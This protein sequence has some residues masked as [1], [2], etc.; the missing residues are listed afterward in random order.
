MYCE[1][2]DDLCFLVYGDQPIVRWLE[3]FTVA[4]VAEDLEVHFSL[5]QLQC[6][7]FNIPSSDVKLRDRQGS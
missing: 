2:P 4:I 7:N 1:L 6:S 5:V 3:L